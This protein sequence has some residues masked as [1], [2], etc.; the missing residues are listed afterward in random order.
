MPA[1]PT[2]YC[3]KC[4]DKT[5]KFSSFAVKENKGRF[6]LEGTCAKC[7]GKMHKFISKDSAADYKK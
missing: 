2:A 4:K 5:A 7:S 6:A 1:A 3:M